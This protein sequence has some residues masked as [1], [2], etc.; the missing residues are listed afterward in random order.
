[1]PIVPVASTIARRAALMPEQQAFRDT[2][3]HSLLRNALPFDVW[4]EHHF[5]VRRGQKQHPVARRGKELWYDAE[6]V[7]Q[8]GGSLLRE[9]PPKVVQGGKVNGV[10]ATSKRG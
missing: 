7:E 1:M 5:D 8:G 4:R 10:S 2:R 9:R 3:P 6:Q